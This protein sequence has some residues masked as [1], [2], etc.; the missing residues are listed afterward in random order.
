M[1]PQISKSAG[2]NDTNDQESE[3][4]PKY[5]KKGQTLIS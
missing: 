1:K 5:M 2:T 3:V 4:L